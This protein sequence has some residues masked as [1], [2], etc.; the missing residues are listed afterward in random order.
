MMK[1]FVFALILAGFFVDKCLSSPLGAPEKACASMRPG[2]YPGP[3]EDPSPYFIVFAP[4]KSKD[5]SFYVSI[6]SQELEPFKGF[7]IQAR[8]N[9]SGEAIGEWETHTKRTRL[10]NCF[11]RTNVFKNQYLFNNFK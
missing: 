5:R 10:A 2:H 4:A 11:N 1:N 3:Q 8:A 9:K 7:F 6:L